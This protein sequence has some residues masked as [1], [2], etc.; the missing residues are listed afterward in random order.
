MK[1]FLLFLSFLFCI[2]YSA[3]QNLVPNPDFEIYGNVPCGWS[4]SAAVF[5]AATDSWTSPTQATPDILSTLITPSCPN[6]SPYSTFPY[7]NG[8]QPPHS[9]N[10]FAG[11]YVYDSLY[12]SYREYIQVQLVQPMD[13]GHQYKVSMYVSLADNSQFASNNMGV[14]FSDTV[15]NV[16]I[17]D[18]L[19]Y[20]PQIIFT[21]VITDTTTNWVYLTDTII[22]TAEWQYL[23][24]GNFLNNSLTDIVHINPT[25]FF[26]RS[27]YYID[28]VSV[29][30]LIVVPTFTAADTSICEK[31]CTNFMDSS[32]NNPTS[33]LWLFPGGTPSTSPDKNPANICYATQGTYD[34]TL[35]T[36]NASGSDTLT[37]TGYITVYPTPLFPIITQVGNIL[38]SSPANS[39]QW[40]LNAIDI[41]GATAQ[42]YTVLQSGNYT[43][44][45]GDSIGCVNSASIEVVISGI[46]EVMEDADISIY[47]NPT[48]GDFVVEIKNSN[49]DEIQIQITNAIGEVIF[50]TEEKMIANHIEIDLSNKASG[51]YIIQITSRKTVVRNKLMLIQ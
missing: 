37:L 28:D 30:E 49:A 11:I 24:I 2:Y 3:A 34:V 26:D 32:T 13:S 17:Q 4:S 9:G 10:I 20:A 38:T 48:N 16:S 8:Y 12:P 14:G 1:N 31:F 40:Q 50:F 5:A 23:I 36:T 19:G 42:S 39:Y 22:A 6:Y 35:I 41:P 15:T 7:C 33:W 44:V 45:I 47:P 27:Y 21:D 46:N 25:V 18:E 29:E 51:A 43:V